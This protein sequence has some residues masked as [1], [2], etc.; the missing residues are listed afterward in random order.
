MAKIIMNHHTGP[1][2]S[3]WPW[4]NFT[5]EEF[6]SNGNGAVQIEHR[7]ANRLQAVRTEFDEALTINSAYRDPAYNI[8]I[9]SSA[10]KTSYHIKGKAFDVSCRGW[11]REKIAKFVAL[12]Y[13]HGFGGFGGYE[14]GGKPN[15]IHIDDRGYPGK[16]GKSWAWP[17]AYMDKEPTAKP[18]KA[19]TKAKPIAKPKDEKDMMR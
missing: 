5:P 11:S 14:K 19:V 1:R 18:K 15:F 16:W 9:R 4:V 12:A 3:P 6:A 7:A 10:P 13:K 17:D 8:K 2:P